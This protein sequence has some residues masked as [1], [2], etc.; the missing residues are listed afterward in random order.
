[1]C[2][3]QL[4]TG[5]PWSSYSR[6]FCVIKVRTVL[7]AV[8]DQNGSRANVSPRLV[9]DCFLAQT[10]P[11]EFSDL[12]SVPAQSD[13]RPDSGT[14]PDLTPSSS[15]ELSQFSH[16][17]LNSPFDLPA[18]SDLRSDL[19][20]DFRTRPDLK[21]PPSAQHPEPRCPLTL[22]Q[23]RMISACLRIWTAVKG[24]LCNDSPEGLIPEDLEEGDTVDTKNVLSYSFRAIHESRYDI[25]PGPRI[26]SEY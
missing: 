11:A 23:Q 14:R 5:C 6:R 3:E 8:V 2:R 9:W 22:L 1:M 21:S 20:S 10:P 25:H 12:S 24:I 19:R 15:F 17:A 7:S 16:S 13:L 18:R 4:G 26:E